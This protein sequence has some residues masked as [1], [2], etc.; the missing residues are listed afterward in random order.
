MLL[1]SSRISTVLPT[2]APPKRPTLPPFTYGASRSTTLIPVSK[3][4]VVGLRLSNAG[5]SRW[6]GQRSPSSTGSP[7]STGSPSTLKIRPSVRSPTGTV[8]GPPVSI[9]S[10]PR[11]RPSV[12]SMAIAR[13]R[14]SPRC[15][16][17]SAT[18]RPPSGRRDLER[19]VDRGQAA[20]ED[21]VDDD[22]LDLDDLADVRGLAVLG[23]CDSLCG[24]RGRMNSAPGA[25]SYHSGTSTGSDF[26]TRRGRH[27]HRLFGRVIPSPASIR[28]RSRD[29]ATRAAWS[30]CQTRDET[31]EI[32]GMPVR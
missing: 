22:T 32:I 25:G 9:T 13:T 1:I 19:V 12:A 10:R 18:S 28:E 14:P 7:L 31:A 5:G 20:R 17:T 4:S 3:I 30:R 16:C 23:Q 24:A 6:I 11:A 27:G 21:G 2:P 29:A 8:I 15:C 26:V